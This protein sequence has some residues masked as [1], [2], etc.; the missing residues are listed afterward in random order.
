MERLKYGASKNMTKEEILQRKRLLQK[1]WREKHPEFTKAQ[2]KYWANVYRQTKPHK[3]V[4]SKCGK[5][6]NAARKYFCTCPDCIKIKKQ[7]VI[8]RKQSIIDKRK[9]RQE[10]YKT[11]CE[12]YRAGMKQTAIAFTLGRA[13]SGI[14]AILR[15][16]TK[17]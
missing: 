16:Y 9:Q 3:C 1:N 15:R 12:L 5:E 7:N 10:E 17:R 11:I 4:C 13:Q 14:S 6:F 2:N 8:L